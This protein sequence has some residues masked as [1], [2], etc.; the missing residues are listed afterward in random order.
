MLSHKEIDLDTSNT[1]QDMYELFVAGNRK[2]SSLKSFENVRISF[3][4]TLNIAQ[5]RSITEKVCF[6]DKCKCFLTT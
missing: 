4:P 6:F 2:I 1:D 3:S 5:A